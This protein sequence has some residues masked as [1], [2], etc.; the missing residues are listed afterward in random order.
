MKT[1]IALMAVICLLGI[2]GALDILERTNEDRLAY[3]RWVADSCIP[4]RAG[5]SAVAVSDGKRLRCTIY[6]KTGYGMAPTV[7]SAAVMDMPL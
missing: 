4:T 2:Y 3:R 7:V 1:L 6:S 5:E